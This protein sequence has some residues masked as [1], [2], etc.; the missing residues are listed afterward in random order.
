MICNIL[1]DLDGTLTDPKEGITRCIQE[2]LRKLGHHVPSNDE[3]E[4]C[5]GPSL[6]GSFAK[7]LDCQDEKLIQEAVDLY[8]V[9]Y[10]KAG[11]RENYVYPDITDALD[12]LKKQ[13]LRLFVATAKPTVIAEMILNSFCLVKF[14]DDIYGSE[15]NGERSEKEDLISYILHTE[16]L[17]SEQTLM[18]GYREHDIIGAK[19]NGLATGGVCYGYGTQKELKQ[20]GAD[21]LFA[22]PLDIVDFMA[23]KK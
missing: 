1:F 23:E 2:A 12:R 22:T 9:R 20:A 19:R 7:L 13:G 6:Y 21:Y 5:I 10:R 18:V 15:L 17:L 8:R 3:L 16:N 14:F 4:W 11:I